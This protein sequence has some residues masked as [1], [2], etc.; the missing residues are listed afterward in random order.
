MGAERDPPADE[1]AAWEWS[2]IRRRARQQAVILAVVLGVVTLAALLIGVIAVGLQ[3]RRDE[4]RSADMLL[5]V[6]PAVPSPALIDHAFES[7][8]RGYAPTVVITGVGGEALRLSLIERGVPGEILTA[9]APGSRP[10]DDVQGVVR[11]AY[12]A[13]AESTLIVAEPAELLLWLK[14]SHDTGLLAYGTPPGSPPGLVALMN[15]SFS[16]WRYVLTQR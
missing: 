5:I 8:R 12:A 6:A 11:S 16:Y 1:P 15:G 10:V 4:A 7:Y 13:G 9:Q 3:A 14:L 2:M